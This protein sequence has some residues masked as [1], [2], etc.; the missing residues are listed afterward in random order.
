MEVDK[1]VMLA[2]FEEALEGDTV[3]DKKIVNLSKFNDQA[4][5]NLILA[6]NSF[7]SVEQ[8]MLCG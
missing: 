2:E 4:Y 5:E 3:L 6:M 7:S 8:V 1:I